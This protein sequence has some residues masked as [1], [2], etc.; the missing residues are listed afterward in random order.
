MKELQFM[1]VTL[2]ESVYLPE[3]EIP[4]RVRET[5][6]LEKPMFFA[7]MGGAARRGYAWWRARGCRAQDGRREEKGG[8]MYRGP[9]IYTYI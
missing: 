9:H 1:D 2:R 6:K 8:Y 7:I 3:C 5:I 4:E